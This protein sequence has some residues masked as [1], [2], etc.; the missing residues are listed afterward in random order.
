MKGKIIINN[1]K[2]MIQ[3]KALL[4]LYYPVIKML[5]TPVEDGGVILRKTTNQN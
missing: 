3:F 5:T 4:C 2:E 1:I